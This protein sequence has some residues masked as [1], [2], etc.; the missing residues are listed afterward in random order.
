MARSPRTPG[1]LQSAQVS[2]TPWLGAARGK[3]L[4]EQ[5]TLLLERNSSEDLIYAIFFVLHAY[6]I[7][8]PLVRHTVNPTY[9]KGALK[10]AQE[11]ATMCTSCPDQI[12]AALTDPETKATIDLLNACDMRDQGNPRTRGS[13]P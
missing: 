10:N 11:F 12:T 6:V 3:R 2:A 4:S 9:E 5:A 13:D 8:M 7:E 1:A